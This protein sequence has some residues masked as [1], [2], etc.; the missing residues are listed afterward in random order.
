MSNIE[1]Y[2]NAFT[3][4]FEIEAARTTGLKYQDI[5]AWDSVGHMGLIACF[6]RKLSALCLILMILLI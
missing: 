1:K 4:T 3:S 5:E 2:I 6:G